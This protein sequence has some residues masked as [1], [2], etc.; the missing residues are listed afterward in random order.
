MS[1]LRSFVRGRTWAAVG[2]A[3]VLPKCALCVAG[4]LALGAGPEICGNTKSG[5]NFSV[6]S[7]LLSA[8]GL[9]LFAQHCATRRRRMSE[10]RAVVR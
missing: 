7:W 2:T 10:S 5:W 4:Y 8:I 6:E 9:L 1:R 3:L